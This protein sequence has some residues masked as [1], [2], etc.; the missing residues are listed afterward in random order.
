MCKRLNIPLPENGYWQKIRYGKQVKIEKLPDNFKGQN[1]I[2][3]N[4]KGS[5]V[6]N[7]DSPVIKQ[8]RLIEEIEKNKNLTLR[9]P[10]RLTNPNGLIINSKQYFEAVKHFDRSKGWDN[11]PTRLNVL[12]IDVSFEKLPRALRI[13]NTVIKLIKAS[14]HEVK[15]KYNKTYAIIE[16]EEIEFR[17]REKKRATLAKDHWGSTQYEHTGELAFIIG[18]NWKNKE[19]KDD[20]VELLESKL[21]IILAKLELEGLRWKELHEEADR[22][23]KLR[24]ERER[25]ERELKERKENESR[26]FKKLFSQ[27]TRLHHANILRDYVQTVEAKV[28]KTGN[29]SDEMQNW[30]VWAKQ[31][32]EWYDPLINREDPLLDDVYKANI[33]REFLK[34]WQ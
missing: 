15:I 18:D 3:L 5:D 32:I 16:G 24:E 2:I 25:I 13:M 26:A 22:Q 28:V 6:E 27:A 29:I 21:S 8:R 9:V 30:I 20:S 23:R 19:V 10:E 12:N 11:Y 34:E 14:N 1:E 17:I 33:F 31:K 4:E 7:T